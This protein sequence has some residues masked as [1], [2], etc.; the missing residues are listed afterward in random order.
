MFYWSILIHIHAKLGMGI[1]LHK[2]K[3]EDKTKWKQIFII[4]AQW[5]IKSFYV[6]C[7]RLPKIHKNEMQFGIMCQYKGHYHVA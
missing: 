6:A 4:S 1:Y 7:S 3:N 5:Q 2:I